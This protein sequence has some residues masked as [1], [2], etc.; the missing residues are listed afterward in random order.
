MLDVL[1]MELVQAIFTL[2]CVDGGHTGCSLAL[3]SKEVREA[4]R[5]A[6]FRC[7]ALCSGEANQISQFFDALVGERA[8]VPDGAKPRLQHLYISSPELS[9]SSVTRSL[10]I[11]LSGSP[12]RRMFL[13]QTSELLALVAPE[14]QTLCVVQYP[15]QF[16][17]FDPLATPPL[18]IRPNLTFPQLRELTFAGRKVE[19]MDHGD[20]WENVHMGV[21][22]APWYPNLTRLNVMDTYINDRFWKVHASGL[23]QLHVSI[24][25]HSP[26]SMWDG[27]EEI[28]RVCSSVEGWF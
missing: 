28:I 1:P 15:G 11:E 26:S 3:V 16:G 27:L 2:A 5:L 8:C 17:L 7:I 14:L 4:S 20:G 25:L 18:V 10:R 13:D 6:R 23:Q 21:G 24:S 22:P 19:F 12:G 9:V